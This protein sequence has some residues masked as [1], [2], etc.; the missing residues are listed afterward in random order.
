M[1]GPRRLCARSFPVNPDLLILRPQPGAAETRQRATGLGL[2]AAVAPLFEVEAVA[3]T[4]PDPSSFDAVMLTSAN[5]AR[6]A[7]PG[8]AAYLHLL[9]YAVGE[10]SAAAA[11]EAG[12]A[13]IVLGEADGQALVA[14]MVQDGISCAFHP[15][16]RDRVEIAS[17]PIKIERR[18]VYASIPLATLPPEAIAAIEAKALVL[19]HS[20]RAGGHFADLIDK[21]DIPRS[22]IRLAAIS[23]AAASAA[24]TGWAQVD[25]AAAPRDHALL[26]LAAGLCKTG[27]LSYESDG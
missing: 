27:G 5:A 18:I 9:C 19:I 2:S 20:P 16:G 15:C 23:T 14:R 24:G 7:G 21:A 22:A 17:S 11:R 8:L 26:E 13:E 1:A 25:V 12:F 4:A 10:S 3:W 6:R